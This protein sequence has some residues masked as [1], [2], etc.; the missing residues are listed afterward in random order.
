M[1]ALAE[2]GHATDKIPTDEPAFPLRTMNEEH[3]EIMA[4]W[5]RKNIAGMKSQD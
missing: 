5:I 2:T 1:A 3:L 4:Q